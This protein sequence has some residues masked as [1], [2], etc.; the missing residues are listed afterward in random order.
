MDI[1]PHKL[2]YVAERKRS[3]MQMKTLRDLEKEIRGYINQPRKQHQLLGSPASWNMLCSCLDVVGDT[4]L[5]LKAYHEADESSHAG[6]KY[7]MVFGVL[8]ILF[9]QQDAVDHLCEALDIEYE[10]APSLDI[11]REVRNDSV[12][13]PTKCGRG[14]GKSY[15]FIS[16]HT[17]T[18]EGFELMKTFL[19][20]PSPS[21][22]PSIFQI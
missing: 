13:H 7:L 14:K 2:S 10:A 15:N 4:Q 22:S 1:L 17:L 12:G 19:T 20:T 11:I 9:V 6:E 5:A 3:G 21:S 16:R 18:R 8:Q